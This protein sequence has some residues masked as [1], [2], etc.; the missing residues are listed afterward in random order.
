MG[1]LPKKHETDSPA[2]VSTDGVR[3]VELP[4]QYLARDY[5]LPLWQAY[6]EGGLKRMVLVW[7]RRA[8]KDLSLAAFS[9]VRAMERVGAYYHYFPTQKLGRRVIWEGRDK[10]GVKMLDRFPAELVTRRRDDFMRLDLVN[11]SS[12]QILGTDNLDVVG[13]NPVGCVFSEY[14]QQDPRAWELTRPILAE[15]GGW[16]AFAYTPRG[17]NHGWKLYQMAQ[18]NP[19]WF[20]KLLTIADTGVLTPEQVESERRAGMSEELIQQEFYCSFELGVEGSYYSK[21]MGMAR[22]EGRMCELALDEAHPVYTFWDLGV[23]DATTI[24]FAQFIDWRIHLIDYYEN[25][26]EGLRHYAN[27]L[28]SKGYM[29]GGHFYPHDAEKRGADA[30]TSAQMLRQLGIGGITLPRSEVSFGIEA[31]RSV[32]NR[33]YWDE[34]KCRQGIACLEN[35]HAVRKE[36]A[37][38]SETQMFGGPEHDWSSHGADAFRYLAQA[39]KLGYI[40]GVSVGRRRFDGGDAEKA[41]TQLDNDYR[42]LV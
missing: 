18:Q 33:C 32:L 35:Y 23:G 2:A 27:H 17:K 9:C 12:Y 1:R 34:T 39:L 31:V 25:R 7:H 15:N 38:G 16:A 13:V 3:K 24:W 6:E 26:N 21:L 11:G 8:G 19:E 20:C 37:D 14:P 36:N 42:V 41:P 10:A 40:K 4:H 29:Y 30:V 5:Q 28:Q 22:T